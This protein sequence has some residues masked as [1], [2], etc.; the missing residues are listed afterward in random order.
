MFLIYIH[1]TKGTTRRIIALFS[2]RVKLVRANCLIY[3]HL[4]FI[5][6]F[7]GTGFLLM[8]HVIADLR[9]A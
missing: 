1:L 3:S 8:A 4:A 5:S 2:A 7:S 6:L 9:M